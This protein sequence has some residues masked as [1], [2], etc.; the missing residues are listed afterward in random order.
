VNTRAGAAA[1]WHKNKVS[2]LSHIWSTRRWEG[3]WSTT[4]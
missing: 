1:G 3:L 2:F 4:Y